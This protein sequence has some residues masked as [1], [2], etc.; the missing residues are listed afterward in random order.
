MA[1]I[2]LGLNVLN[3]SNY[4]TLLYMYTRNNLS[5]SSSL[6]NQVSDGDPYI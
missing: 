6:L 2:L 5:M 3:M 1:S 4:T